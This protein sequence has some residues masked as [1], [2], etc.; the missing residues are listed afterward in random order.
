MTAPAEQAAQVAELMERRGGDVE[1][2]S[3]TGNVNHPPGVSDCERQADLAGRPN[4]G[5]CPQPHPLERG[6]AG[7][8]GGTRGTERVLPEVEEQLRIGKRAIDRGVVR[9]YTHVTDRPVEEHI[10]LREERVKVDRRPVDRPVEAPADAFKE[11]TIEFKETVEE[12]VIEKTARVVGEVVVSTDV[13]ERDGPVRETVRRSRVEVDRGRD[14]SASA[15]DRSSFAAMESRLSA[16]LLDPARH[17]PGSRTSTST[18]YR[19]GHELGGRGGDSWPA[20]EPE[21]RR[22]WEEGQPG[23]WE[24][25]KD[26]IRYGWDRARSQAR[27]A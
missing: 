23:T 16:A 24:R 18:A 27:A 10:R 2:E 17:R 6:D 26:A 11:Q 13:R 25:F 3:A 19:Y 1:S 9:V 7:D 22:R 4:R 14:A 20:V 15:P 5:R 12:P 21:A 8:E